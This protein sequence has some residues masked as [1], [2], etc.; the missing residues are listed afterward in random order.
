MRC[1]YCHKRAGLMRRAC[2]PCSKVIAIVDRAGGEVGMLGMV[3]IF[4]AEGLTREQVDTVLDAEIDGQ[5]TLRDQMTSNIA[6]ALMRNLGMP[7]RQSPDDVRKIREA[8]RA[9]GGQGT[10]TFD[11]AAV[12]KPPGM[13]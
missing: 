5:P 12:H 1:V 2:G 11:P 8:S 4:I 3:D 13:H 10:Y 9:G 7:G 6:N